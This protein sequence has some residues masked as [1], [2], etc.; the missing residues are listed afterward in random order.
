MNNKGRLLRFLGSLFPAKHD[1]KLPHAPT[2][3]SLMLD[4]LTRMVF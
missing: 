3:L 2:R 4:N 1:Q